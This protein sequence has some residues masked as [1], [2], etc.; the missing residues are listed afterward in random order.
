MIM[1]MRV[2]VKLKAGGLYGAAID[3]YMTD[4]NEAAIRRFQQSRRRSETGVM[5]NASLAEIDSSQ[6]Q[7]YMGRHH[8]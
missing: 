2:Q 6:A 3:G 5:D 7:P 4:A 8:T 1:A